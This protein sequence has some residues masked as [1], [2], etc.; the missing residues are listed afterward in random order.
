[1]LKVESL[2]TQRERSGVVASCKKLACLLE[3]GKGDNGNLNRC[4]LVRRKSGVRRS[5]D[6]VNDNGTVKA[7]SRGRIVQNGRLW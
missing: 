1:M 6:A 3:K 2:I 5:N 7:L 4:V